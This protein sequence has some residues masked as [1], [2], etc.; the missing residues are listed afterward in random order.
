MNIN[1]EEE[2]VGHYYNIYNVNH[3]SPGVMRSKVRSGT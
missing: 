1:A 2:N 3:R